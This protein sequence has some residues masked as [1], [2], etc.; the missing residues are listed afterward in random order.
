PNWVGV[1]LS[2]VTSINSSDCSWFCVIRV[3]LG[4]V[5]LFLDFELYFALGFYSSF[6]VDSVLVSLFFTPIIFDIVELLE[7][8]ILVLLLGSRLFPVYEIDYYINCH[9]VVSSL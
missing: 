6:E 7:M 4:W 3:K 8:I 5:R 9:F 1:A 2:I